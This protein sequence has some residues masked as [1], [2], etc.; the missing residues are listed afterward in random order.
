[1]VHNLVAQYRIGLF[2]NDGELDMSRHFNDVKKEPLQ[3]IASDILGL[4]YIEERPKV[5]QTKPS[6]LKGR[7]Y[8][9]IAPHATSLAKYWNKPNG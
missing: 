6:E 9:C 8:V 3:K 4:E 2:Y 1:M 5:L 7:K